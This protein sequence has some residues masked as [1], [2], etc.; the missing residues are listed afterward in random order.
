VTTE[1]YG[2]EHYVRMGRRV[3]K[4]AGHKA[5]DYQTHQRDRS[6]TTQRRASTTERQK[7]NSWASRDAMLI[8]QISYALSSVALHGAFQGRT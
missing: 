4:G 8:R 1:R 2:S 5:T 3:A 7:G 6:R